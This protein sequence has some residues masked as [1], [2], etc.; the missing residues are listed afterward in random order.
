MVSVPRAPHGGGGGGRLLHASQR[1]AEGCLSVWPHHQVTFVYMVFHAKSC[2]RC[3]IGKAL[4]QQGGHKAIDGMHPGQIVTHHGWAG[5]S[6]NEV[7][8]LVIGRLHRLGP[9][10]RMADMGGQY[11]VHLR[12]ECVVRHKCVCLGERV[13]LAEASDRAYLRFQRSPYIQHNP[14]AKCVGNPDALTNPQP[15]VALREV[16]VAVGWLG[17]WPWLQKPGLKP[18]QVDRQSAARRAEVWWHPLGRSHQPDL[19]GQCAI[20]ACA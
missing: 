11:L 9:C 18:E 3:D 14:V 4:C 10:V 15:V 5:C 6:L 2:P 17:G 20:C 16:A 12:R 19:A 8:P 1:E 13:K 7:P